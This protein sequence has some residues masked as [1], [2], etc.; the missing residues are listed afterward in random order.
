MKQ[1]MENNIN[2]KKIDEQH[3]IIDDV[4]NKIEHWDYP[5]FPG[6]IF[7]LQGSFFSDNEFI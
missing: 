4:L 1:Y 7:S 6:T 3:F 2:I 5:E